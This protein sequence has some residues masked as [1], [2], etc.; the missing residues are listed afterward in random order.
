MV[1]EVQELPFLSVP[2]GAI[3]LCRNNAPLFKTAMRFLAAGRSVQI[4]GT[5]IGK[6]LIGVM[7]KLGDEDMSKTQCLDAVDYWLEERTAKG[8]KT[9][10]DLAE[11]MR[12]FIRYA[13]SLSGA[14]AYAEH[15][16]AAKG[17]ILFSPGH[18]AKGLEWGTV[19]HLDPWLIRMTEEQDRNLKYVVET[20]AKQSLYFVNSEAIDFD[21]QHQ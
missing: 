16:L 5:D 2:D 15:L 9:A 7:K 3:F 1:R 11:C 18:K 21:V 10:T 13:N 19:Y 20:R 6:R 4:A 14:I 12:V 8:N 17:T